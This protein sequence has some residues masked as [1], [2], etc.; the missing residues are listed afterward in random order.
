M[1]RVIVICMCLGLLGLGIPAFAADEEREEVVVWMWTAHVTDLYQ[2]WYEKMI[3]WFEEENPGLTLRFEFVDTAAGEKLM[4]AV[5]GGAP[6]DVSLASIAHART[7][8]EGGMFLDLNRYVE[9]T[10]HMSLDNFLPASVQFGQKD[11]KIFGLP[12]SLEARAVLYNRKHLTEAGLDDRP[13]ALDTWDDMVRYAQHLVRRDSDGA[14]FRSG[15]VL[16]MDTSNFAAYLYSNGGSFYNESG[17]AVDFNNSK[18]IE[19]LELMYRFTNEYDVTRPGAGWVDVTN[20]SAS[21]VIGDTSSISRFQAVAPDFVEWLDMAPIPRGP[22]GERSSTVSWSNMFVIPRGASNPD[23]S[24]RFIELWLSPRVQEEFFVH[25][26]AMSIRSARR[27]FFQSAAFAESVRNVPYM[28]IAP[29]IF[30][31]AGPYP[32]IRFT[33]INRQISPLLTQARNGTMAPSAAL[34][35]AERIANA[36]L[37]D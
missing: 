9:Q 12:W 16:G 32:Y 35:E 31:Y 19:A 37:Q 8:Y 26:G 34:A 28:E 36:I 5:A 33:D 3:Q 24:W 23:R 4:A 15:M 27:D 18:G 10:P 2:S 11:G 25:F 14:I 13:Q 20:E 17:T 30:T 29:E 6:P 1:T 7:F 21:M 22:Q